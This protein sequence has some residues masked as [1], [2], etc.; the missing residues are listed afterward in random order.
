MRSAIGLGALLGDG[1]SFGFAP[2]S[3][4]T[5]DGDAW[6]DDPASLEQGLALPFPLWGLDGPDAAGSD[7]S[8]PTGASYPPQGLA[9]S[10]VD[11][12]TAGTQG[13]ITL[14]GLLQGKLPG[15][16]PSA[17]AG[18]PADG[19]LPRDPL[20][21][22]T[23]LAGLVSGD[24]GWRL[25]DPQPEAPPVDPAFSQLT[26][27][28]DPKTRLLP[29]QLAPPGS[30]SSPSPSNGQG[31]TMPQVPLPGGG[32]AV[33]GGAGRVADP[34]NGETQRFIH[35]L[36]DSANL[37][38]GLTG[39]ESTLVWGSVADA[40]NLD[41]IA[42]DSLSFAQ[43]LRDDP[44]DT[45]R[46]LGPSLGGFGAVE[47]E[48]PAIADA[49]RRIAVPI[50]KRFRPTATPL[51]NAAPRVRLSRAEQLKANKAAGAAFERARA[52]ELGEQGLEWVPQITL[53][54]KS[55]T[56]VRA[57]FMTRHPSTGKIGCV[58]CKASQTAPHTPAQKVGYP[59]IARS[60]GTILGA[61]KPGFPG[62][63]EIPPT[64][65]QILRP[66]IE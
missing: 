9:G 3:A 39:R 30:T 16:D 35:A 65:V 7:L 26:G 12:R 56:V 53:Q 52:A 33:I 13:G 61:G 25:S 19:G 6:F 2:V 22:L 36:L 50:L 5:S 11:P 60:G 37:E 21:T 63:M 31:A 59:E 34:R 24:S 18:P 28:D 4:S 20:A 48:L 46:R 40:L 45:L 62:G 32:Q 57:D 10:L 47:G 14:G 15:T 58:D 49:I 51:A 27:G 8:P 17:D 66:R 55:G 44:L 29:A 1:R 42:R 43:D 64:T 23:P 41:K 54:T 38:A